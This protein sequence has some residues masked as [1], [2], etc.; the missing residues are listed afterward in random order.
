MK[1]DLTYD[2]REIGEHVT[3]TRL[4]P[5]ALSESQVDEQIR[6]HRGHASDERFRGDLCEAVLGYY[7]SRGVLITMSN[8]LYLE[9]T[10][11]SRWF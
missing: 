4:R 2:R 9:L 11:A 1:P 6:F 8:C 5:I 7:S 3:S 10:A